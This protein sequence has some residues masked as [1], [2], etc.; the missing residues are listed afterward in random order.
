MK[1][2]L[3]TLLMLPLLL[4]AQ[5]KTGN[6]HLDSLFKELTKAKE[7]T[8]KIKLLDDIANAEVSIDPDYG[9]KCGQQGLEMCAKLKWDRGIPWMYSD[10]GE[11]YWAKSDFPKALEYDLKALK[12]YETLNDKKNLAGALNDISAVYHAQSDYPKALEYGL[13]ALKIFEET[14]NKNGVSSTLVNIGAYYSAQANYPKALDYD[15]KALTVSVELGNKQLEA[16]ITGNIG[17]LYYR[18]GDTAK[19]MEYDLKSLKM[20]EEL[21]DK[22]NTARTLGNMGDIFRTQGNYRQALE[23]LSKALK[24][25][26]DIGNRIGEVVN[27]G[28]IGTLYNDQHNYREALEYLFRALKMAEDIDDKREKAIDLENIGLCYNNIATDTIGQIENAAFIQAGEKTNLSISIEY[29]NKAITLFKETGQLDYLEHIYIEIS[30]EQAKLGKYK[31][32]LASYQQHVLYKDSVYSQANKIKLANLETQRDLD[33]KD[34]DIEIK[35][36]QLEIDRL[37]VIKKRNERGFF[38]I[39]FVAIIAIGIIIFSNYKQIS[40]QK[41]EVEKLKAVS[42]ERTRIASDMHD[43]M[44]A[45]L[46]SI[47]LLSELANLKTDKNSAAKAEIEKIV[48]SA[49]ALSENLKEIIWTMNTQFD[50]MEDFVIYTRKYAVEFF[51]NSPIT[52]QFSIPANIPEISINGELRRNIFLCIKEALNNIMKHSR[53]TTASLAIDIT[54]NFLLVTIEDNGIGINLNQNNRFGNGLNSIKERLNKFAG[55]LEIEINDG[56]KLF[57]KINILSISNISAS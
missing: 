52:F 51:D 28:N 37:A 16:V 55:K 19:K 53:A 41:N 44:G 9:I 47:R 12:I 27:V 42:H 45:G 18:Q 33:L 4:H 14:G 26:E 38:F 50:R 56:T 1:K 43:D 39:G 35:N 25:N 49:G 15:F 6:G 5:K 10:I 34:K 23:Y 21:G 11:N 20:F 48:K 22:R 30:E 32:A 46:T 40:A 17:N 24:I 13:K 36:K 29:L 31:E 54:D 8:N 3:F 2:L 7:D 57:M